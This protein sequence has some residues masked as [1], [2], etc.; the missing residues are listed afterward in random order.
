[1]NVLGEIQ[2]VEN[3][4][5]VIKSM[6]YR[7]TDQKWRPEMEIIYLGSIKRAV[8]SGASV[9]IDYGKGSVKYAIQH[10]GGYEDLEKLF[11]KR[12]KAGLQV[13]SHFEKLG[14]NQKS[15]KEK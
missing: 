7:V 12:F 15:K 14:F 5:C 3:N 9:F 8:L 13:V 11:Q 1:M 10:N 4:V 2:F 6:S